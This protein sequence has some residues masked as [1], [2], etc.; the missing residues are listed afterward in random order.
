ML[1][2][3]VHVL[4]AITRTLTAAGIDVITAQEDECAQMT[5]PAFLYRAGS[6]NRFLFTR[7]D[8]LLYNPAPIDTLRLVLCKNL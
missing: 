3:D 1:Y 7:D 5:G 8:D 2:M 6:L 4:R